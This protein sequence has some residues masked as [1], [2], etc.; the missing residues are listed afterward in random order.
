MK[1]VE[2]LVGRRNS[3]KWEEEDNNDNYN[4]DMKWEEW[5][6]CQSDCLMK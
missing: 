3:V 5:T 4:N 6:I 2:L 1:I